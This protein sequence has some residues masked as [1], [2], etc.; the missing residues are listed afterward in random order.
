MRGVRN[1]LMKLALQTKALQKTANVFGF[2][3]WGH[4]RWWPHEHLHISPE[5][6]TLKHHCMCII[7]HISLVIFGGFF[8]ILSSLSHLR[9]WKEYVQNS[10]FKSP[11]ACGF[12]LYLDKDKKTDATNQIK[13]EESNKN[14]Y[15]R[16]PLTSNNL[17][18]VHFPLNVYTVCAN[19]I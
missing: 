9:I 14:I 2:S 7:W 3:T 12:G 17:L 1:C 16:Q 8:S 13:W 19:Q 18:P 10:T 5:N 4:L 15:K 6:I 11:T